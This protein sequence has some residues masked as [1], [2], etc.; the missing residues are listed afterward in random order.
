MYLET[1]VKVTPTIDEKKFMQF[2][3]SLSNLGQAVFIPLN[4]NGN[5]TYKN[6][7]IEILV[8]KYLHY[9]I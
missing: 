2:D 7:S 8:C 1:L 3:G 4:I 9:R 6:P 5:A